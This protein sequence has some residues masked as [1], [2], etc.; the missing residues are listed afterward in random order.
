LWAEAHPTRLTAT[1]HAHRQLHVAVL[2]GKH[3][4]VRELA[5]SIAAERGVVHGALSL[6]PTS[7][8]GIGDV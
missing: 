1:H 3:P 8:E 2:R 4:Q 6:I 5:S 7:A